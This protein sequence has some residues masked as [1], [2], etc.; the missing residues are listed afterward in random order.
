MAITTSGTSITF[1]DTTVQSTAY[2]G[3][4]TS[5]VAG[6]GVAVSGA[7]GAVTFSASAPTIGSVG[8]YAFLGST[9]TTGVA[10]GSTK[11]GSNL[12][13]AGLNTSPVNWGSSPN[14]SIGP[15]GSTTAPAGTWMA[16]GTD[17]S[18]PGSCCDPNYGATVWVRT[19]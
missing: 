9:N 5:A 8:S 11:A 18:N 13:Y 14:G 12:R 19:V 15:A 3:A 16:M 17:G 7:T 6:N 4:V 2:T 10:A 1:N